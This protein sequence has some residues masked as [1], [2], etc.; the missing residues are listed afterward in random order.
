[1]PKGFHISIFYLCFTI[2]RHSFIAEIHLIV[3]MLVLERVHI[4]RIYRS[5]SGQQ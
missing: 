4:I 3:A 2:G 5:G 1:M